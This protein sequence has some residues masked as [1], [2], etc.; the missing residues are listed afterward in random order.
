MIG[1]AYHDEVNGRDR[2]RTAIISLDVA[3]MRIL[4]LGDIGHH[5]D[6]NLQAQCRGHHIL[7]IPIGGHST[8]DGTTAA[9]MIAGLDGTFVIPMHY[10]TSTTPDMSLDTL[11]RSKF[12]HDQH[13]RTAE[14]S[15]IIL[16]T[17][18][19]HAKPEIVIPLTPCAY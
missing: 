5:L 16:S 6:V 9:D 11:E 3:G 18:N 13:V 17:A 2:G 10:R 15:E 19:T 1:G 8:I 7:L 14:D 4:H 12:L